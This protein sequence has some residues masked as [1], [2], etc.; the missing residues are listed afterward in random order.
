VLLDDAFL[1]RVAAVAEE[2]RGRLEQL[3]AAYPT[4]IL[5]V[6]GHGLLLGLRCGPPA[7]DL[8]AELMKRGLVAVPAAENVVRL[9]PPLIIERSHV[10]EA[11]DHLQ[12]VCR[13]HAEGGGA[14]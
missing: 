4:V 1:D 9:L 10:D 7:A 12:A 3:A 6:R 5:E 13:E 8:V 11:L 2:L 14:S